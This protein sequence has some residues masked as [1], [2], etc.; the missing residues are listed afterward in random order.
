MGSLAEVDTQLEIAVRLKLL[1]E[2]P[3]EELQPLLLS[4]RRLILGLRR[5][6]RIRLG[7]S[8]SGALM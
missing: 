5:A 6:K 7:L 3:F 8:M 1:A 4:A 2:G